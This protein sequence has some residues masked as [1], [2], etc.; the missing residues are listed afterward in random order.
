M[1]SHIKTVKRQQHLSSASNSTATSNFM[2]PRA[3]V[4]PPEQT[5]ESD[6]SREQPSGSRLQNVAL[7]HQQISTTSYDQW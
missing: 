6:V 7:A 2:E 3:N 1:K 4:D 5:C